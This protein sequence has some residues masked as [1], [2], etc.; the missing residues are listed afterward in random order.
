MYIFVALE[1][2]TINRMEQHLT[3]QHRSSYDTLIDRKKINTI[4]E[5][6]EDDSVDFDAVKSGYMTHTSMTKLSVNQVERLNALNIKLSDN[7]FN[8]TVIRFKMHKTRYWITN[9]LWWAAAF[10]AIN[11]TAMGCLCAYEYLFL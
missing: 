11:T 2:I 1:R 3:K 6:L 7:L 10:L 5:I 4:R 9:G 8:G